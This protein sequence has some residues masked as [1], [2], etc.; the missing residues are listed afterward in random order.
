MAYRPKTKRDEVKE[1][2]AKTV[3]Y[4]LVKFKEDLNQKEKSNPYGPTLHFTTQREMMD[5]LH[6]NLCPNKGKA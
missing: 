3:Y 2:V 5:Y 6:L 4:E 1:M